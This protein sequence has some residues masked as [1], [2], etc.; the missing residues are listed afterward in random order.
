MHAN[1]VA[2]V[3]NESYFISTVDTNR[4][5]EEAQKLKMTGKG[6]VW[7][8]TEQALEARNVPSGTLGLR[9]VEADN[10]RWHI[11]DSL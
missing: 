1:F 6:Y 8:V 2:A 4:I 5:F 9:L 10:E 3:S 7:I 11:D